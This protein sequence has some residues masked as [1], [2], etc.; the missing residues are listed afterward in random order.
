MKKRLFYILAIYLL[1]T[2]TIVASA[3][4]GRI[5]GV[6]YEKES[7]TPVAGATITVERINKNA[8]STTTGIFIIPDVANGVY[9]INVNHVSYQPTKITDVNVS[10]TSTDTVFVLLEDKAGT[11]LN[12]VVVTTAARS[13]ES[14]AAL[15][16]ERKA[17]TIVVQKIGA[18]EMSTKGISNVGEGVNKIVGVSTVGNS[19]LFVR[20]LE[21]RY[22][23]T[24]LNGLPI[25]SVN[26]DVKL[27]PL[28][29]FPTGIVQ[30]IAVVK[31]FTSP[32][33]GDFSGGTIDIVTKVSPSRPF[34]KIGVSTGFNSITTGKDFLISAN[35]S[36][37]AK[38]GYGKGS[39]TLPAAMTA[40]SGTRSEELPGQSVTFST[41]W[42]PEQ[43]KAPINYGLSLSGGN[44]YSLKNGGKLGLI[45]TLSQKNNFSYR[46]GIAAFYNASKVARYKYETENFI[47]SNNTTGLLSFN[48]RK[49][50]YNN[51]TLTSLLVNDA[52]T[53]L[54]NGIGND[55]DLG[56]V[57]YKRNT[58]I[59]NTLISN[60][61]TGTNRLKNDVSTL[62]WAVGYS[63]TL[64]A[65][66][67][68][69]TNGFRGSGNGPYTFITAQSGAENQRYSYYLDDNEISG[70]VELKRDIKKESALKDYTI[71]VDGKYKHR[72]FDATVI[73][74]NL[75]GL[76]D[77]TVDINNVDAILTPSTMGEAGASGKWAV[78]NEFNASNNYRANLKIAAPYLNMNWNWNDKW[79]LLAG[80][81]VE[82]AQQ[83]LYYKSARFGDADP[84]E[85]KDINTVEVL[86]GAT[87][88][89]LL[90][91]KSNVLL[92]ASRTITRPMFVE[93]APF[94]LNNAAATAE[95]E[96]NPTLKNSSI[97]NLD[98][99]YEHYPSTSELFAVSL[100]G[101]YIF[102]P[103]EKVQI[104]N[105]STMFSFVNTGSAVLAGV[106]VEL[107][108]NLGNLFNTS[109]NVLN[110]MTLGFNGSYT[111]NQIT[112]DRE[113]I[114]EISPDK[115]TA[116]TNT[117]RPL[118]GASPYLI[119]LDYT[120]KADWS[121]NSFTTFALA[122]NVFGK[123]LY[124][125]GS[126]GAGDIYEM[127]VNMLNAAINTTIGKKFN[128]DFSFDNLLNPNIVFN[129]E[130][131]D[132]NLEF[133]R[134]KKGI[135]GSITIGYTF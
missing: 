13:K 59:Q 2:I 130:F 23:N 118:Y 85:R 75:N 60:Q 90:N 102:D 82:A 108:R 79:N 22:N 29:I 8:V 34:F 70:K 46:Q 103:I 39:R 121:E 55:D 120:Y 43:I 33:Y 117:K 11:N 72:T 52:N 18:Q 49:N 58:L 132:T 115:P 84:F 45:A 47:Q 134:F 83:V 113:R 54:Y 128:I 36:F 99:K 114:I 35:Q 68:R 81:R 73:S 88:K 30:N 76:A 26:P 87:L 67:D 97:Y 111:Y 116:P 21:D 78:R 66:P 50:N 12:E 31:S 16:I 126:Q 125:A 77:M 24:T 112:V 106:E 61:L 131:S 62:N 95:T 20:G 127:P 32:Y 56:P 122:Y 94:R 69:I 86:P 42:S 123:R 38:Q 15:N 44:T 124:V 40:I 14:F 28:D 37:M 96:G 80:V 93:T 3:Q 109:S 6:V 51:Y 1:S 101:K 107:T 74:A 104:L 64:G 119:N 5:I 65:M 4:N 133:S 48:Y 89:R 92:A 105:A 71:G 98:L 63:K 19:D 10:A 91:E 110:N 57:Y 53:D 7:R 129:Q 41:P 17:S 27:I 135:T 25:P 100:F 9:N